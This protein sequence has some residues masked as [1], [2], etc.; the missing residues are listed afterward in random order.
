MVF[1]LTGTFIIIKQI[2]NEVYV[3]ELEILFMAFYF[4]GN[5]FIVSH[6]E[7]RILMQ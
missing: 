5:G 6:F 2:I 4:W 1:N 3:T 7:I